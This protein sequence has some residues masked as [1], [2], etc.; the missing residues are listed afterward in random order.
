MGCRPMGGGGLG[1]LHL[2]RGPRIR[3]PPANR[4][5]RTPE[6]KEKTSSE[7]SSLAH[8]LTHASSGTGMNIDK[9]LI[10]HFSRQNAGETAPM[11][12]C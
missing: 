11:M 1:R 8:S 9:M 10:C 2:R 4:R 3:R 12:H 5:H 6:Q 7:T